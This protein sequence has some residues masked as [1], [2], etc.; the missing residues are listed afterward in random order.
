MEAFHTYMY[1]YV[2]LHHPH[3]RRLPVRPRPI[4][5]MPP[6]A[7]DAILGSGGPNWTQTVAIPA[8]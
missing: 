2:V 6:Y 3:W 8:A 1:T 5:R 4:D 7:V